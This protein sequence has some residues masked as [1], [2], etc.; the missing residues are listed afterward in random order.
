MMSDNASRCV[1]DVLLYERTP[2]GHQC[3]VLSIASYTCLVQPC[4]G[5]NTEGVVRLV[6]LYSCTLANI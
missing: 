3:P 2:S 5:S 4:G 1:S 6:A